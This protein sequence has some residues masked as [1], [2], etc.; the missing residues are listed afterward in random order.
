MQQTR[1][2]LRLI[3][4]FISRFKALLFIGVVIGVLVFV[5]FNV[6]L[7]IFISSNTEIIG[8]TGRYHLDK[9]P[10][11]ILGLIGDG[12][13]SVDENG[14]V[15]PNLAES[16]DSDDEGKV[17]TFKLKDGIFW[18]DETPVTSETIQYNFEDVEIERPDDHT[19]VF[20]LESAFAPFPSVVSTPTFK[21]G[22]LG[23]GDWQV[24]KL[25]LAGSYVQ[26]LTLTNGDSKKIIN[27]YPTEERTKLAYKLGQI[28]II[29]D[30]I[31][32]TPFDEWNTVKLS[33]T[34]N[35]Q[36]FVA[37]FFN[38]S[39]NGN[40]FLVGSDGK[41]IRQALSYAIDKHTFGERVISPISPLSWAYN[42]QVKDYEYD[43]DRA[44][45][46]LADLPDEVKE[47]FE[48]QL[49][50]SP[51]LLDIA[52]KVSEYWKAVGV[53]TVVHVVSVVPQDFEAFLAIYEIPIDPDQYVTWHSTQVETNI[54]RYENPR[55]DKLLE[56]GRLE[57]DQE[58]R[59]KIY[60]DFQRFLL[61]D[62][63]AI[64]LYHPISYQVERK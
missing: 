49:T 63:P 41:K 35:K 52:E 31:N 51:T 32:P 60:L 58:S 14:K 36:R 9:L 42:P 47:N 11:N 23:T 55:I 3:L 59:K 26:S 16:W 5:V 25:D 20:K 62:A 64:F 56:D 15:T 17:W 53:N 46:L 45:E 1:Y 43:P 13:T 27:F 19:L 12:L 50:T 33:R 57:L 29:E 10:N 22:L 18:H 24:K 44:K 7:P 40:G 8:I 2:H 28:D 4:A 37:I 54:S 48:V 39:V 34:T 21:K 6:I 30:L 38:T 61:E